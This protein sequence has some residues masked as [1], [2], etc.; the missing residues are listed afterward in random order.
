MPLAQ[1]R[2]ETKRLRSWFRIN[3]DGEII[4]PYKMGTMKNFSYKF[5]DD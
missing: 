4:H 5:F 2:S 3:E 1:R